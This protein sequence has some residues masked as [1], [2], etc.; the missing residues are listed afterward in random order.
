M[1]RRRSSQ[2]DSLELLLDTICNMF[3][4]VLFLAILIAVLIRTTEQTKQESDRPPV[5]VVSASELHDLER[6]L[7][8]LLQ[9]RDAKAAAMQ[10]Q[11]ELMR[12]F[13]DPKAAE[14]LKSIAELESEQNRLE[15]D[16]A[17]AARTLA[18]QREK[19]ESL[20]AALVSLDKNLTAAELELV[21]TQKALQDEIDSRTRT[22]SLPNLRASTKQEV[23][24]ILRFGRLYSWHTYD[25]LGLRQG[26]NLEDM[27]V[28][29]EED[30]VVEVAPM[31]FAGA[32]VTN[33][34]D[35]T[36]AVWQKL[37]P[38]DPHRHYIAVIVYDDSFAEFAN[39][40]QMLI[41]RGFEYRLMPTVPGETI[42]DH[43]GDGGLVQ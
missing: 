37:K 11:R 31:P 9:E 5:E 38:F 42:F 17:K 14:I 28:V 2:P 6:E 16:S 29:S 24:L 35:K 26:V 8:E 10:K 41:E 33:P 13:V 27:A 34:G 25:R 12:Q 4:G 21:S 39:L 18:E 30:V 19:V 7:T 23:G 20:A 32:P 15:T 22:A 3:G 43:G 36:A 1:A 40:K